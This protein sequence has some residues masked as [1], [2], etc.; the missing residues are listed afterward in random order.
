[1]D[2]S[3]KIGR[4]ISDSVDNSFGPWFGMNTK[5]GVGC[6]NPLGLPRLSWLTWGKQL[7]RLLVFLPLRFRIMLE[8]L[9]Q[10]FPS[11]DASAA[12]SAISGY[13]IGLEEVELEPF[14]KKTTEKTQ[15]D[16]APFIRFVMGEGKLD[17]TE[18]K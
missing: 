12:M 6:G 15:D 3:W 17:F 10:T 13:P 4:S 7:R 9:D 11:E 16:P 14:K 5:K 18:K 8:L 1:M 2:Y